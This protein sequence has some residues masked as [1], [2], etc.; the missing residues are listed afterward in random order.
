MVY[1]STQHG[2]EKKCSSCTVQIVL[3]VIFFILSISIS[4][5]ITN[6]NP[7]TERVIY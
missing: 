7:S 2:Y 1:N 5:N 4:T 6:I 3:S